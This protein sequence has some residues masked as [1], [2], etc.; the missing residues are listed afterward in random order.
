MTEI[1]TS[2]T[3]IRVYLADE[4]EYFREG[5]RVLIDAREDMRVAGAAAEWQQALREVDE[6]QP[7]VVI[8]DISMPRHNGID[9]MALLHTCAPAARA[10]VLSMEATTDHVFH[11]LQAGARGYLLKSSAAAEL[12]DAVRAV[13]VGRRF[14]SRKLAEILADQYLRLAALPD[15]A[16]ESQDCGMV[17]RTPASIESCRRQLIR[18]IAE[19]D[20]ASLVKL[21]LLHGLVSAE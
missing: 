21:A 20:P 9:G 16:A 17:V 15:E 5:L 2:R 14:V 4:S 8:M 11:A 7:D 6:L 12:V 13:H 10:I 18:H 3:A 19:A 1:S